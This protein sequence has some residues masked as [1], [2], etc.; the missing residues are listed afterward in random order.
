MLQQLQLQEELQRAQAEAEQLWAERDALAQLLE[1]ERAQRGQVEALLAQERAEAA[2]AATA[3]AEQLA[4]AEAAAAAAVARAA[5]EAAEAEAAVSRREAEARRR[6]E[7]AR[8]GLLAALR[9][10]REAMDAAERAVA[11]VDVNGPPPLDAAGR[12][13][14]NSR[15]VPIASLEA[16]LRLFAEHSM[17]ELPP[18]RLAAVAAGLLEAGALAQRLAAEAAAQVEAERCTVCMDRPRGVSLRPCGH[19]RLC[20]LCAARV[21]EC[22]DCRACIRDRVRIIL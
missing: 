4:A 13:P 10:Q 7:E 3:A 2:A 1:V 9:R 5:A 15:G 16:A 19:T 8:S 17:R 12:G 21:E 6:G 18:G 11:D 14:L 20:E 22:P